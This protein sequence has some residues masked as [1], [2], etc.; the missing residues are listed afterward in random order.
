MPGHFSAT[1]T[2]GGLG[3]D[4]N[5]TPPRANDPFRSRLRGPRRIC[6][7]KERC[8][9]KSQRWGGSSDPCGS[10]SSAGPSSSPC[11]MHSGRHECSSSSS[12]PGCLLVA[13]SGVVRRFSQGH[14][15]PCI[16]AVCTEAS[17]P[18]PPR[19]SR[20]TVCN[21]AMVSRT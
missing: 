4:A 18:S 12:L 15:H 11:V 9:N 20:S 13:W 3:L 17:L 6:A 21:I 16:S 19:G 2:S 5:Q 10:R 8:K 14:A 7:S 1:S